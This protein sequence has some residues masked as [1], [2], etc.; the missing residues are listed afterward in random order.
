MTDWLKPGSALPQHLS[1]FLFLEDTVPGRRVL[2]VGGVD[3]GL[4]DLLLELG[5]RRVV[6]AMDDPEQVAQYREHYGR[7]GV[8]FR[9]IERGELPGDDGAFDLIIDFSLPEALARGDDWRRAQ[10]TG[11]VRRIREAARAKAPD[12]ELSAAVWAWP[13]RAYLSMFQDWRG[14]IDEELLE[15]AHAPVQRHHLC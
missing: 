14:W 1:R 9:L 4:G 7:R 13:D 8:D 12:L 2:E 3:P 10:V 6:S 11:L 15:F 5:A